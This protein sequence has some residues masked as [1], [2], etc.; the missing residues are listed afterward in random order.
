MY[1]FCPMPVSRSLLRAWT[2]RTRS[3]PAHHSIPELRNPTS[4]REPSLEGNIFAWFGFDH[5]SRFQYISPVPTRPS[6]GMFQML[7][8]MVCSVEFFGPIT[9]SEVVQAV[10]VLE[11][12]FPVVF[13]GMP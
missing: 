12:L 3:P 9:L 5:T 1:H 8:K 6:V 4:L 7:A 13:R 2:S 11:P 10:H